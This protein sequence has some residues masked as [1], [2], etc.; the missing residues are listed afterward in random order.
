VNP[1]G[2]TK[3][4]FSVPFPTNMVWGPDDRLYVTELFG[5]IHAFSFG[6]TK[7]PENDQV[8]TALTDALGP[9]LTLGITVDPESTPSNVILWVSHSSPSLDAGVPNSSTITRLS[10]PSFSTVE[11][12]I[13]GLPRALANHAVNSIHFGPDGKLYLAAGGNTGGGAPNDAN[14]EFGTMEE[15][16]LSAALL[17]ADVKNP[18]F[19]GSCANE[20]DIF[21]PPPCDVVPY[22]TGLRNAYDFVFHSNGSIYAPDNG[23][24][25]QGTFPPSPTPPCTGLADSRPW[26]EGG[27][28]PGEQPDILVRIQQGKYYGHPNPYRNECVFKDGSYQGVSP[29]PNYVPPIL[30]LGNNRSA[31]GTVEYTY[32]TFFSALKGELLIANFSVGDD[33][34]R[35]R[36]TPDGLSVFG[37]ASLAGGFNDPLALSLGPDGTIYVSELGADR[38][39]A[40]DP[41]FGRWFSGAPMAHARHELGVASI[42]TKIYAIGGNV[43]SASDRKVEEYDTVTKTWRTMADL[44][45][46]LD[47]I[48][49]TAVNNKVYVF[50]GLESFPA[51]V[52]ADVYEFD[53]AAGPD[54]T[55]SLIS[56][57]PQPAGGMA[58][59]VHNG[60]I[61]LAGGFTTHHDTSLTSSNFWRFDP[62]TRVWTQLPDI[63]TYR[64]HVRG[65][66]INGKFYV[67]GGRQDGQ[68]FGR[69]GTLEVYDPATNQWSTLASMPT[70][71]RGIASTVL[72]GRL[73]VLGG[74]KNPDTPTLVFE[75]VEAYDPVANTWGNLAPMKTPRHASGA[76]TINGR[77]YSVGGATVEGG[78][79]PSN[80][81]EIFTFANRP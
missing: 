40:M 57:M 48:G 49:V 14:T 6:E 4:S 32:K 15:Q 51:P 1:A 50:G 35:V 46:G 78:C 7:Q 81:L 58:V 53:P 2:F 11:H 67:V 31:D 5:T 30:V 54:G 65:E 19:D 26:T 24:S 68:L 8:I 44:P 73:V 80:L 22:A 61:Y 60:L 79:C 69:M 38:V 70:P 62:V 52:N 45:E 43:D 33:I 72:E 27:D 17:V 55:W 16:P 77:I 25:V 34:T 76:V 47:H 71:R 63:P 42:G 36:L 59:G 20:Q 41:H 56:T 29:L 74:E 39:T 18:N 66:F 64:D 9:R 75:E 13:T 12:I 28:S 10:G 21:G 37:S 3:T 23:L